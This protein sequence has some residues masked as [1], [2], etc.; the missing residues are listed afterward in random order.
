M[1]NTI[2]G[3]FNQLILA[4]INLIIRKVMIAS[5]GVEYLGVN[6]L[7]SNILS[8]LSLTESGLSVAIAY[9]LYKPIAE[10]DEE[11]LGQL[12]GFFNRIYSIIAIVITTI[13][14][15]LMPFL[16]HIIASTSLPMHDIY[17]YYVLFLINNVCGYF[18]AYKTVFLT[19]CQKNYYVM[20]INTAVTIVMSA[21]KIFV[22]IILRNY[23]IFLLVTIINTLAIN[24]MVA[25]FVNKQY[26]FMRDI[27]KY[28]LPFEEKRAI[29]RDCKALLFHKIGAYVLTGTDN[30]LISAFVNITTVGLYSNYLIVINLLNNALTKLFEAI[31]PAIGD[32]LATEGEQS[33]YDS[34]AMISYF[35]FIIQLFC[36]G[37]L[38]SLVQ[39]FIEFFFGEECLLDS[40]TVLLL[41][42]NFFFLGMRRP[43]G[44]M[45]NASGVFYQDRY[46]AL[47]E[48][49][50]NLIVSII[51]V[52]MIGLPGIFI[53]T[54][55]SGFFV[56]NIVGPYFLYRDVF[57]VGFHQYV[58]KNLEYYA[59]MIISL[60]PILIF[61][62]R[63][64]LT[65]D[66]FGFVLET[67][68]CLLIWSGIAIL[69][70][71]VLPERRY[72][73]R[74]LGQIRTHRG[75]TR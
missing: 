21:L 53:G 27:R 52:K 22:L 47:A 70:A 55:V 8:L 33:A 69:I 30:I 4:I 6:G 13:G 18:V 48:A 38:L 60:F 10:N 9:K 12:L 28:R 32:K 25:L 43:A 66:L 44:T 14:L 58:F 29:Y 54:I 3:V 56:P 5:I 39:P 62:K 65:Y 41:G 19:A 73:F 50:I 15:A 64:P 31:V 67:A 61:L 37:M 7:F 40:F 68:R 23:V 2:F 20:V 71:V 63:F 34:F 51:G 24:V 35:D 36:S 75:E 1:M 45:K 74:Y 17:R 59:I 11:R 26:P 49:A 46:W 16:P 72:L 42:L 57:H